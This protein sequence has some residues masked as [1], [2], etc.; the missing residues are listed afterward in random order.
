MFE[1][2]AN[3]LNIL[4]GEKNAFIGVLL[5]ILTK[6][7]AY[8]ASELRKVE[9]YKPLAYALIDGINT[10]FQSEFEKKSKLLASLSHPRFKANWIEDEAERAQAWNLLK[11]ELADLDNDQTLNGNTSQ[12]DGTL[13]GNDLDSFFPKAKKE[14]EKTA[15]MLEKYRCKG[16][17]DL[18]SLKDFPLIEKVF[19]KYNTLLT[20]SASVE[21]LFSHGGGIFRKNRFQLKDESFEKQLLLKLNLKWK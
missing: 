7:K 17:S 8:L 18:S 1:Y 5:P 11:D 4:Q 10:R 3:A 21:R 20:S 13:D 6:L 2:F 14:S 9:I 19:R 16:L 15:D 12:S